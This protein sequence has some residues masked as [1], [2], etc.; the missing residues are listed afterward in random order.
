MHSNIKYPTLR[1][2]TPLDKLVNTV[3]SN[4]IRHFTVL[5][6][7]LA[8]FVSDRPRVATWRQDQET[9]LLHI[10]NRFQATVN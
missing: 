4:W 3:A 6:I 1:T 8:H 10:K 2:T 5:I 9:P 7:S